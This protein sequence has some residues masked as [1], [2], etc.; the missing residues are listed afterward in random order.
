MNV[1]PT[2][3]PDRLARRREH[4]MLEIQ[5]LPQEITAPASVRTARPGRRM[6]RRF[7]MAGGAVV[8]LTCAAITLSVAFESSPGLGTPAFAV[9]ALPQGNVSITVVNTAAS[10]KQMTDQ[11]HAKGVNVAIE[12]MPASR[13]LVGT[14][15]GQ[16]Y[17][18]AVPESLWR[19][20]NAQTH[21]Y[22]KTLD[23]PASFP[24]AITLY[25]GRAPKAGEGVQVGGI[26]NALAPGGALAC[27]VSPGSTPD[28][29]RRALVS[30]GYTVTWAY[31]SRSAAVGAPPAGTRVTDAY[32]SDDDPHAVTLL[33]ADP[34]SPTYSALVWSGFA[35]SQ[36]TAG[37]ATAC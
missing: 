5:S 10:A 32:V 2:L 31:Q 12:T 7:A 3:D 26:R 13:Q 34:H 36:R 37:T 14:W 4:L 22:T 35:P 6:P 20:I 21:G 33:V 8:G 27:R 19:S 23:I 11:L 15:V 17:S 25:V 9:S 18:S 1:Q 24:G 30:A 16:S 29:A 28:A